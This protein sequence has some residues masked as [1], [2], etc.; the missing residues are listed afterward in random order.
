MPP[1]K[2]VFP[3]MGPVC[4][5]LEPA[6]DRLTGIGRL[7]SPLVRLEEREER[8]KT[9]PQAVLPQNCGGTEP[10]CTVICMV[11]NANDRRTLLPF[12]T[13]NFADL[14]SM[15]LSIRS[16]K[17]RAQED[18]YNHVSHKSWRNAI[19]NLRN[20]SRH[21][22]VAEF[23]LSTGHDCLRNNLY[24]ILSIVYIT[25]H[26]IVFFPRYALCLALERSW[27]PRIF[28][29]A[30][31]R[32]RRFSPRVTVKE[33][34]EVVFTAYPRIVAMSEYLNQV[35]K[36]EKSFVKEKEKK[37]LAERLVKKLTKKQKNS[38][39]SL[40]TAAKSPSEYK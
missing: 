3:G 1:L 5:D 22:V 39:N 14:D 27:S 19:L 16:I 31:L 38:A 7:A 11:L 25:I 2:F 32:T 28:N 23:R 13:M 17:A 36:E 37:E 29:T 8:W 21:R 33:R 34:T 40:S 4:A 24:S 26:L 18:F 9:L 35:H 12:A 6:L 15:F 30:L 10:K 20:V